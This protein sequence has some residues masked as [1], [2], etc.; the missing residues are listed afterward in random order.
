MYPG[1][2]AARGAAAGSKLNIPMPPAAGDEQ[3]RRA[4]QSAEDFL[5]RQEPEFIL[6]QCG[7]DSLAGDPVADLQ[8]S[9]ASHAL[10]A[11]RLCGLADQCCA[12]RILGL[13]GGGYNLDNLAR[14]WCA[15]VAAFA[16]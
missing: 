12:G 6:F 5:R 10:A 7:A 9:E 11:R 16:A 2:V 14:A 13:G 15:V 4:W 3:F 8:Y 1:P